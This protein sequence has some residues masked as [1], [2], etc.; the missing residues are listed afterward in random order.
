MKNNCNTIGI[1]T[2]GT[3]IVGK[4]IV[5]CFLQHGLQVIVP[6][7][8]NTKAEQLEYY[9]SDIKTGKLECIPT[10]ISDYSSAKVLR[11]AVLRKYGRIDMA[12]ASL[13]G[14]YQGEALHELPNEKWGAIMQDNFHSH[15][16]FAKLFLSHFHEQNRGMYV[17]INGS[18]IDK[19]KPGAG[20]ISIIG[21]AQNRMTE[22]FAAEA[23][24]TEVRVHSVALFT[25]VISSRDRTEANA[26]LI[27]AEQT[28]EYIL[29]LFRNQVKEPGRVV[30]K[31]MSVEDILY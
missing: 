29:K 20:I 31:L 12:V 23:E 16:I 15:F 30:H 18:S 26:K 17:N 22:V 5:R 4:G 19:I 21:A 3:G 10:I 13:G 9:V 1:V 8:S 11:S 25:E 28:G 27:S 7:R 24:G 2:G 6:F 14:W